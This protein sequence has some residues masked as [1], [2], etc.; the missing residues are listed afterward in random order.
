M[1]KESA[2]TVSAESHRHAIR[3]IHYNLSYLVQ[4]QEHG[5]DG[6]FLLLHGLPGGAFSW[7]HIMPAL[8][9]ER[10]VYAFDMLSYGKSD[11]PWP[12]DVSIWGQADVLAPALESLHLSNLILV[13]Y[14]VGGGVAQVLTTRLTNA[15]IRAV[16]LIST[17]CYA[18]AF[19]DDWPLPKMHARQEPD[20]PR[21]TP[22]DQLLND[23]KTTFP[24]AAAN[25]KSITAET[26]DQYLA[27]WKSELGKE[28]LFQH[29]RQQ[30][31]NYS[32]SVASDMRHTGKPVLILWG[33]KD[34]VLS[35]SYA[36]RL[37]RDIPDS[38]LEIIPDTG[39]LLLEEAPQAVA[40]HINQFVSKLS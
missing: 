5:P 4:G 14:D 6:A 2:G 12:A 32:M 15:Q 40:R 27:P 36:E 19:A 3:S 22:L 34:Q 9:G 25:P 10:A 8:A 39:H 18:K 7:R 23:F 17:T 30:I 31:P 20:A 37:H 11:A 21:H 29:I 16:V 28:N 35:P 13:G 26:L 1:P 33:E 38:Q 24:T